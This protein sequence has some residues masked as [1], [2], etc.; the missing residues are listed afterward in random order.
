ME[1]DF[2]LRLEFSF[3]AGSSLVSTRVSEY[4]HSGLDDQD[5]IRMSSMWQMPLFVCTDANQVLWEIFHCLK[6]DPGAYVR[7][8]AFDTAEVPAISFLVQPPV[9]GYV[10]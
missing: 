8:T 4:L 10:L 6:G 3:P 9:A 1:K 2:F 7:L 5:F